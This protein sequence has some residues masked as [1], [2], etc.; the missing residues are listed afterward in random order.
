VST[1]AFRGKV[2][3]L[4]RGERTYVCIYVYA[5]FGGNK[6][7]KYVGREVSGL[8]VVGDEGPQGTTH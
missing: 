8:L 6:L 3:A 5:E 1:I 4:R 7:S 2:N